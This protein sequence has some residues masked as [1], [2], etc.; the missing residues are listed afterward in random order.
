MRNDAAGHSPFHLRKH[1]QLRCLPFVPI[2][3]RRTFECKLV[4][5]N[6]VECKFIET[7]DGQV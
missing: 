2:V 7:L 4:S 6:E 3:E 1:R 5:R